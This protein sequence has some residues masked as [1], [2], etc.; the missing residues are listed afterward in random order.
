VTEWAASKTRQA[1]KALCAAMSGAG[2]HRQ[3]DQGRHDAGGVTEGSRWCERQRATTGIRSDPQNRP[4][5]GSR[6][7]P[8][9]GSVTKRLGPRATPSGGRI[10][11]S[12]KE[13]KSSRTLRDPIQGRNRAGN[14][15]RWSLADGR[16]TSYPS[17]TPPASYRRSDRRRLHLQTPNRTPRPLFLSHQG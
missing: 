5:M 17:V 15:Y 4:R 8:R 9:W 1:V 3:Q 7:D 13:P 12:E 2:I 16:T 11:P 10:Q 14:G 6:R